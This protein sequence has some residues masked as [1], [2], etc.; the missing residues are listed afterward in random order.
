VPWQREKER[1]RRKTEART[2]TISFNFSIFEI[3][4]FSLKLSAFWFKHLH[5]SPRSKNPS[6]STQK[7]EG[8]VPEKSHGGQEKSKL[9]SWC[10]EIYSGSFLH[11]SSSLGTLKLFP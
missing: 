6:F 5:P 4:K 10:S 8:I 1:K 3:T 7:G 11:H 9:K 2:N